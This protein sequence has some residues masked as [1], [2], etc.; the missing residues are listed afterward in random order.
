MKIANGAA[1]EAAA[2][3]ACGVR[4]RRVAPRRLV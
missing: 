3:T 4:V 1:H 2:A